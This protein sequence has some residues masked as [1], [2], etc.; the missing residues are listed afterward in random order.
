M[1]DWLGLGKIE[2]DWE[3]SLN[4]KIF[5]EPKE[6]KTKKK[7]KNKNRTRKPEEYTPLLT[8]K[9]AQDTK[10]FIKETGSAFKKL[11]NA[12]K[13]RK[14]NKLEKEYFKTQERAD[15]LAHEIKLRTQTQDNIVNITR[16]EKELEKVKTEIQEQE[17]QMYDKANQEV[18]D[19]CKCIDVTDEIETSTNEIICV[20][21]GGLK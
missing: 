17:A 21:C 5:N 2:K 3:K 9:Q 14:I 13:N 11:V 6:K 15:T 18:N 12:V 8:K 1:K 7:Y 10:K 20:K 16:Y 19:N 4:F